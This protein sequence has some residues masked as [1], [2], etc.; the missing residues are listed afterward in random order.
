MIRVSDDGRHPAGPGELWNESYY[1]NFYDNRTESGGF[2]RIGLRENLK[3]SNVWCLLFQRGRPVYSR[4]LQNLPYTEAGMDR[5]LTVGGLTYRTIEPLRSAGI[6]FHDRETRVDLV[7]KAL[8]PM[9]EVGAGGE[10]LP[11][12]VTSAHL[13][14]AGEVAGTVRLR[15]GETVIRGYGFRDHAWGV[16]DWESMDHY[17]LAWPVFGR[18]PLLGCVRITMAN[19]G[20]NQAGF[21]FDGADNG[22]ID[23]EDMALECDADGLTQRRVALRLTDEKGRSREVTG[24][25]IAG[26][27]LPLDG[28]MIDEAM[29]E[30]SIRGGGVGYGLCEH[31]VRL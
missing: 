18:D 26:F 7:W 24:S 22:S 30:Y 13:E 25:R 4:F 11:E 29:F 9:V 3:E 27:T 14:Q 16:R 23:I 28:F 17:E 8:H 20:R 2:T 5:G 12:S 10:R 15:T 31:G 19:G 6:Q 1:F 21:L